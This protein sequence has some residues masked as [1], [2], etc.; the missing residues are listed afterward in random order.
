MGHGIETEVCQGTGSGVGVRKT[1]ETMVHKVH[2]V[3]RIKW[4]L[5]PDMICNEAQPGRH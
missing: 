1:Q 3:N 5:H 4:V 2:G